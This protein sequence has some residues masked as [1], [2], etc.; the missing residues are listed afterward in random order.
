MTLQQLSEPLFQ[1]LCRLNHAGRLGATT[2]FGA[3]RR[4]IDEIFEQMRRESLRDP[5]LAEH[6][7][8]MELPLVFFVDFS[9][10]YSGLPFA[11][12]WRKDENR[13]AYKRGERGGD[14]K[15]LDMLDAVL[16]PGSH[17]PVEHLAIYYTCLGLGFTGQPPLSAAELQQKMLQLASR[18]RGSVDA[19]IQ[20]R[21]A[22]DAYFTDTTAYAKPPGGT[23]VRLAIVLVGLV[24]V[25]LIANIVLWRDSVGEL[26]R[27]V[28][29]VIE[30]GPSSPAAAEN[31]KT[32]KDTPDEQVK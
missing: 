14:E 26:R 13:L 4:D 23:F 6:Y 1:Y 16:A 29:K 21:M 2:D 24:V 15:F 28:Q 30:R 18:L 31:E 27:S 5:V 22:P 7:K 8:Q 3:T 20:N 19:D 25:L 11:S 12:E 9:I 32:T 10:S 17:A